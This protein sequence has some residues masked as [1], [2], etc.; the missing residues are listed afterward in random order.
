MTETEALER[1]DA[2][3]WKQV[4]NFSHLSRYQSLLLEDLHGEEREIIAMRLEG[5]TISEIGEKLDMSRQAISYKLK[6]IR[7]KTVA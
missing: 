2:F 1:Y 3:L 6:T 5:L 7:R 4:H